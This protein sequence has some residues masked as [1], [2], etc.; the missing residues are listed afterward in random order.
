MVGK[1]V[2]TT[3]VFDILHLGHMRM[4]EAAKRAAGK[5]GKLIVVVAT[6]KTV[7]KRKGRAPVFKASQRRE[8]LLYLKPVDDVVIGFDPFSFGK[9]LKRLKP[10]IVAF[11]YDQDSIRRKFEEYCRKRRIKVEVIVL[12]KFNVGRLDSSS[13]VIRHIKNIVKE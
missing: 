11:G 10:D 3:G 1:T 13:M 5:D 12:P 6:D 4:L 2:I 8:M 9:I 7:R